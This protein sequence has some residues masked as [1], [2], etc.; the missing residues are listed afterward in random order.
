MGLWRMVPAGITRRI[1][2]RIGLAGRGPTDLGPDSAGRQCLAGASDSARDSRR[3]SSARGGARSGLD[4]VHRWWRLAASRR[5]DSVGAFQLGAGDSRWHGSALDSR[6]GGLDSQAALASTA[7][8]ASTGSAASQPLMR[9]GVGGAQPSSGPRPDGQADGWR[10][11]SAVLDSVPEKPLREQAH[12]IIRGWARPATCERTP[13]AICER[14]LSATLLS[15][16]P[17][18]ES[19]VVREQVLQVTAG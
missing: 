7:D 17:R 10:Q 18:W 15:A 11:I 8:L 5:L 1:S 6:F 12:S 9:L 13:S 16:T 3:H 19:S 2:G 4:G 14:M